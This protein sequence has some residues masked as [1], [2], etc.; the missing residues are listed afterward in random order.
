MRSY[1]EIEALRDVVLE[2]SYVLRICAEPGRL[3]FVAEFV[4][5]EGHPAYRQ[6]PPDE[7]DCFVEGT[8]EFGNVRDLRWEGQG[9]PPATDASGEIDYGHIDDFRWDGECFELEGDWGRMELVAGGVDL[10]LKA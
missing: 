6:P 5:A 4:L 8:L 7:S 9:A 3:A 1:V 2:E 10:R